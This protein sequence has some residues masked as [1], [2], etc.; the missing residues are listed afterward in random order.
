MAQLTLTVAVELLKQHQLLKRVVKP[1]KGIEIT[2]VSYDSRNIKKQTMLF[3]KGNFKYEYLL[4]AIPQ[5]VMVYV[6]EHEYDVEICGL[7]VTDIQK[8]MALL[9]AAFYGNPEKK[10][11][12]AA[13]TG[14]KGKTT[15]AYFTYNILQQYTKQHT[16]LFST[17]D[18]I[19]GLHD[20]FKSE[21]TT[22]ESLDLFHDMRKA[23]DN[24]MTHLVMEVSSQ[25]YKMNR[26]YNL[27]YD[28]GVFLN[29]SPDHIGRNEHRD[30]QDYLQC[31]L[32]LV[33]N[34]RTVI[35]NGSSQ[36]YDTLRATAEK[37][38]QHIYTYS[39]L[40]GVGDV[41]FTQ[42][43]T[44]LQGSTFRLETRNQAQKLALDGPYQIKIAGSYN[45]ENATS[46]ALVASL[47]GAEPKDIRQ[48]LLVTKVKGRMESL[49]AK[50]HG[51]VYIDYAHNYLSLK[52]LLAFLK[53][54]THAG[55][56]I[57]VLGSPGDKGIS[58]RP[59]FSEALNEEADE[60]YLTAD[61]P[62][63]EDPLEIAQEIDRFIDHDLVKVHFEMDRAQ[64]IKKA[65]LA[66]CQHDIVVLAGK[67]EDPYQK[68]KGKDYPYPTDGVIAKKVIEEF[69]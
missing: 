16:A 43:K 17:V 59:G 24:G 32:E 46:A 68:I 1:A 40:D 10:L 52:A 9:G 67:G 48:G 5:G 19:L 21:L 58:R 51:M 36:V 4:T 15:S 6:A 45:V 61:D 56:V 30:F 13:Y 69:D 34:S 60:V 63:F 27:H 2:Y 35:L 11:H 42:V 50:N 26:V 7:I 62:G 55:R 22:P 39:S 14:T 38:C 66:S 64:A 18:R 44:T 8:A 33:K 37:Y 20:Q 57:A 47:L 41:C 65:I 28:V 29:I 49:D 12:I 25:A 3:C 31:K 23:V 54:Q 53:K